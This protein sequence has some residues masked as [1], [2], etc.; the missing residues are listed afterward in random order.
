MQ[1]QRIGSRYFRSL[2][3]DFTR[4][5]ERTS[6]SASNTRRERLAQRVPVRSRRGAVAPAWPGPGRYL[7]SGTDHRQLE[8]FMASNTRG[9]GGAE[10]AQSARSLGRAGD[11]LGD[12]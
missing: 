12:L 6:T 7:R 11:V 3:V 10:V 5:P 9:H 1:Y 4:D 2:Y 8:R